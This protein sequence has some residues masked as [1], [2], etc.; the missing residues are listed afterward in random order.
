MDVIIDAECSG[1]PVDAELLSS[2]GSFT[3]NLLAQLNYDSLNPPV[4]D[5]LAVAHH[6]DGDWLVVTPIHWEASHN[7]AMIVAAGQYLNLEEIEARSGFDILSSFLAPEGMT[8]Y[9]CDKETWLLS[10]PAKAEIHAKPFFQIINHSLMPELS[11]LDSTM[12]WQKFFTECQML[13]ASQSKT[14]VINGV[15]VWG[16]AKLGSKKALSICAD[17]D[18][19]PLAQACSKSVTLYTPD[20]EL[21]QFQIVLLKNKDNLSPKHQ[22][23][24]NQISARWYWNNSAYKTRSF[25]WF[26]RIWRSLFHAH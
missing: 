13:F 20:V 15:W 25:N 11:Q 8:L 18:F 3:L 10:N 22:A 14:S 21:K 12:Y 16:G 23:E 6:L 2:H 7:D 19:L 24:L 17:A 9:Y 1:T 26:T 4:A 5:L